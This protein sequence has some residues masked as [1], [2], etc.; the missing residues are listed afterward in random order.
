MWI[1]LGVRARLW[2]AIGNIRFAA[3]VAILV[4]AHHR[5][6]ALPID[7]L[8]KNHTTIGILVVEMQKPIFALCRMYPTALV[9]TIYLGFALRHDNLRLVWT[10]HILAAHGELPT[11][12]YATGRTH[13]PVVTI[14]LVKLWTFSGMIL[15]S[16][17]KYDTRLANRLGAICGKFTYAEHG[18]EARTASSP[19]IYEIASTIF[20]PK[21]TGIYHSFACQNTYR[22]L[23]FSTRILGLYHENAMVRVSPIDVKLAIVV[24]DGRCPYSFAMLRLVENFLRFLLL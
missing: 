13:N 22:L 4:I 5:P 16:A 17:I 24:A 7:W 1:N 10:I 21:R 18:V 11:M 9:R 6:S 19:T 15:L 12:L 2:H 3:S 8:K 23:P 20:V 14:S